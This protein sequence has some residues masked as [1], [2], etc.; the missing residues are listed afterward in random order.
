MGQLT[1]LLTIVNPKLK[2]CTSFQSDTLLTNA[3]FYPFTFQVNTRRELHLGVLVVMSLCYL[4][5]VLIRL[6]SKSQTI[7]ISC[8]SSLHMHIQVTD[9]MQSS[10]VPLNVTQP[11]C[12]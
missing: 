8:L 6:A 10:I 5:H 7:R 9:Q 4:F 2:T 11:M 3:N 12:F 1:K